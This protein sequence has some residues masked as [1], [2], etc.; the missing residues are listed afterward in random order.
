MLLR[1]LTRASAALALALVLVPGAPFAAPPPGLAYDEIVRV[2]AGATPP[3]PGAFASELAAVNA[4]ASAAPTPAPRKRG[5]NIG[6]LT[7][8]A[9]AVVG[10]GNGVGGAIA[11]T[12]VSEV[13]SNAMQSAF[14]KAATSSYGNLAAT[15]QSFLQPK[16]MHYAYW[17]GWE[18][19]DDPATQTATIRKCDL[20]QVIKLDLAAKTYTV[21][22]PNAE[23]QPTLPPAPPHRGRQAPPDPQAPGTSTATLTEATKSLGALRIENTPTTGYDS[24]TT[25]ASTQSTGS[26]R[27]A[28]ASIETIQYLPSIVRPAVNACP[29]RRPP[30]PQTAA[31]AVTPPAGG[32]CRPTFS[33]TRSGPTPP[34]SRLA[35]YA[36]VLMSGGPTPPPQPGGTPAQ[37]T[38]GFLTERGNLKALGA[39]DAGLFSVPPGFTK[40][41]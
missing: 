11:Q 34:S 8:I 3:P 17:N 13:V 29:I 40:T 14:D 25:F 36:L 31:E 9:G 32:G 23:P 21:Y 15:A 24:T 26:C 5:F 2:V 20:G 38:F 37:N 28:S 19:V 6:S 39:A 18:R 10:G 35:L 30:V 33:A 4:P 41:P 16:L 12:V 22:D 1:S 27:D 7:N